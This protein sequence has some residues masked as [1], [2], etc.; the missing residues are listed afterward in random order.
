MRATLEGTV[1]TVS[2]VSE[3]GAASRRLLH[4]AMRVIAKNRLVM[5]RERNPNAKV[6]L[7]YWYQVTSKAADWKSTHDVQKAFPHAKVLNAE[8]LAEILGSRSCASEVLSRQRAR[9]TRSI[10]SREDGYC[11]SAAGL[12]RCATSRCWLRSA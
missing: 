8:R 4:G 1:C 6:S 2:S 7:L 12:P 10:E 3:N 9:T 5:F 11:S